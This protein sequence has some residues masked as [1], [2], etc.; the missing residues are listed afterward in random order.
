MGIARVSINSVLWTSFSDF[1]MQQHLGPQ[2]HENESG[3]EKEITT[4]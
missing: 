3:Q 2:Y 1:L 4:T